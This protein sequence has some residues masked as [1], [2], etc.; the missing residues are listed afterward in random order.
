MSTL[1]IDSKTAHD[2]KFVDMFAVQFAPSG[3]PIISFCFHNK[4]LNTNLQ[5]KVDDFF[6]LGK[7]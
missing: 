4:V 7:E 2:Q 3:M 6:K 5:S 1:N